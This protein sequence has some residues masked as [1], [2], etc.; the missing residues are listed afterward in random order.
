MQLLFKGRC[1]GQPFEV[2]GSFMSMQPLQPLFR[3]FVF[4]TL[5]L[6]TQVC[7]PFDPFRPIKD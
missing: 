6:L 5:V 2:D 3:E 1:R 7:R 4:R